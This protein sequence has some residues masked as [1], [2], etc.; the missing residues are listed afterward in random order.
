M[1]KDIK[2]LEIGLMRVIMYIKV[3]K[4]NILR[5]P[6]IQNGRIRSQLSNMAE[7]VAFKSLRICFIIIQFL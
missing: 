2:I 1:I 3:V 5:K 4:H 6:L 7:M